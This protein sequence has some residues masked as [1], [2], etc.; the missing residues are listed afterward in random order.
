[1]SHNYHDVINCGFDKC[2]NLAQFDLRVGEKIIEEVGSILFIMFIYMRQTIS[3][4][5]RLLDIQE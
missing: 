2:V 4:T 5:P 1:M 3:E